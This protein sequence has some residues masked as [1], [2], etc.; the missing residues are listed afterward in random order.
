MNGK[1]FL[2]EAKESINERLKSPFVIT[3]IISW[4]AWNWLLIYDV[5]NFPATYTLDAKINIIDKYVQAQVLGNLTLWPLLSA[6][7]SALIFI[8]CSSVFLIVF[9]FY[10]TTIKSKIFKLT[11]KGQNIPRIWYDNLNRKHNKLK[12][13]L[14]ATTA[15]WS[16]IEEK[17]Q[18][19]NSKT[20]TLQNENSILQQQLSAKDLELNTSKNQNTI[21]Q[22]EFSRL[23]VLNSENIDRFKGRFMNK[24][25][26]YVY[27]RKPGS[28]AY[29][30]IETIRFNDDMSVTDDENKLT[31]MVEDIKG[32]S[33]FNF[34]HFKLTKAKNL[35]H[36]T[37]VYL[38]EFSNQTYKG[39]Y[40]HPSGARE[41]I[42][43]S[44][45]D[46]YKEGE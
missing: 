44:S 1:E 34:V 33:E 29:A 21:F 42:I 28:A 27:R 41:E 14:D 26:W 5:L 37:I 46:E 12:S 38:L 45:S 11:A 7:I 32:N 40:M 17:N 22:S 43:Y 35:N 23:Q 4:I 8:T 20:L 18:E 16:E 13:T 15:L 30:I 10:N 24:Q 31:Y 3:F 19:L 25:F 39:W 9:N 36:K 2:E 6:L